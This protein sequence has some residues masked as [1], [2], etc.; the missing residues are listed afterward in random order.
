MNKFDKPSNMK[1][2]EEIEN[3]IFDLFVDLNAPEESMNYPILYAS[4]KNGWCTDNFHEAKQK[5]YS[6]KMMY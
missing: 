6:K 3:E 2:K 4:A 1:K 5:Q